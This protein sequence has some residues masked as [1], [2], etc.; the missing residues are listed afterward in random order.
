MPQ[1]IEYGGRVHEFPDD[2]TQDEIAAALGGQSTAAVGPSLPTPPTG[3][4]QIAQPNAFE[5]AVGREFNIAP[6]FN[7]MGRDLQAGV[8]AAGRGAAN[9][10]GLP[11]DLSVGATN[12]AAAGVEQLGPIADSVMD[13]FI[14]K[15]HEF[16]LPAYSVPRMG[17]SMAGSRAIA[18]H[19]ADAMNAVGVKPIERTELSPT[20]KLFS[21][22]VETGT[23]SV[24]GG[25]GLSQLAAREGI[26]QVAKRAPRMGDAFLN[27]YRQ[28]AQQA[29]TTDLAAGAGAGVGKD[30]AEEYL[31]A[32][33]KG[34]V[35]T[36][37]SML[38]GGAGGA[39][40]ATGGRSVKA[41]AEKLTGLLPDSSIPYG[42]ELAPVSR[43]TANAAARMVQNKVKGHD[44]GASDPRRAAEQIGEKA[45]AARS[46]GDPTPTAGIATDDV[47]LNAL[48]KGFRTR[49]TKAFEESDEALRTAAQDKVTGVRDP[50]A[51]P[52]APRR[53]VEQ[54]ATKQMDTAQ[55]GVDRAKV[56]VDQATEAEKALGGS[57]AVRRGGEVAASEDLSK[58]VL[59]VKDVDE[60]HKAGLYREAEDLGKDVTV[61]PTPLIENAKAVREGISRLSGTEPKI[62]NI[63]DDIDRLAPESGAVEPITV[64]DLIAMRPRLSMAREAAS[65]AKQGDVVQRI[66]QINKGI[67]DEIGKLADT[68]DAAAL[69]WREAEQNFRDNFAPKYREGVGGQMD[70]AERAGAPT[71]PTAVA[72]KFIRPGAGGKEAAED[73]KRI[74]AGTDQDG[75]G[76]TAAREYVLS[77]MAK[78]VGVDGKISPASLRSWIAQ[79][80]G[81]FQAMPELRAEAN[82]MLQDVVNKRQATGKL[83]GELE[84]ATKNLKRT[85]RDIQTSATSLLIDTDPK[86]AAASVFAAKDPTKAMKEIVAKVSKDPEAAKGWKRAVADHLIDKVTT[87]ATARTGGADEGPVSIA[88]LQ[89]FFKNN[90][91]A[92]AEAFTPAEMNAVRRAHKILEPLGNLSRRATTGS[93]TAENTA[94]WNS[95]DAGLLA[96]TGNAIT[97]GMIRKRMKVLYDLLPNSSTKVEDLVQR[98]WFD[99]ELAQHLLTRE[100]REPLSAT[101]N[102]R[103]NQLIA[104]GEA[105]SESTEKE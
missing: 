90:E 74:L 4:E 41:G 31:P 18:D 30:V 98:M 49:N 42:E 27:P 53:L 16:D 61:D 45:A 76:K 7:Q 101:W 105:A 38:V 6:L 75:N 85:E 97:A 10:V 94:M 8:Q 43:N 62:A 83:Q 91:K 64:R 25:A 56:G 70:K 100:T 84:A 87:T 104:V 17:P 88:A 44:V 5:R 9:L 13:F 54:D 93:D 33:I 82:T 67:S 79:R 57:V 59:S 66:D 48:E 26:E 12:L 14:P 22:I 2:A 37:L 78:V 68:G 72:P 60:A 21:D 81:V 35:A 95:I 80:E 102:K 96:V 86:K 73:L 40:M 52:M 20:G 28:N 34:P 1:R 23:E 92:L 19:G 65:R 11:G 71:P 55:Q 32:P 77:D 3:N 51:D 89:R 69:K 15:E 103:L 36:L 39:A 29:L 24:V 58:A 63:L 46:E 47:G 50:D 99:P